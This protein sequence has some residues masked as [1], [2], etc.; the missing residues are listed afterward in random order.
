MIDQ[1]SGV[2]RLLPWASPEGK[3]CYVF[4]DGAGRVSR[5]ADGV[6]SR[7]LDMADEL[8]DHVADM[9]DAPEVTS[10]QLRYVVARLAESLR[11]LHRIARSRGARLAAPA[12]DDPGCE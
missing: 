7:Q 1:T 10:V 4:G 6:E 12:Y 5:Y 3:P 2:G 11:D 8:L 9:A